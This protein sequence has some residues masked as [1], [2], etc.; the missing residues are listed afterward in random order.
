MIKSALSSSN[1]DGADVT[2]KAGVAKVWTV[3]DKGCSP[4][5]T[6]TP[7]VPPVE[8]EPQ[9]EPPSEA[10]A[11]RRRRRWPLIVAG[12]TVVVLAIIAIVVAT[13]TSQE[14]AAFDPSVG[15]Y[16]GSPAGARAA[17]DPC[18]KTTCF[19][20]PSVVGLSVDDAIATLS[21][22]GFL[23]AQSLRTQPSGTVVA[24]QY[25]AAGSRALATVSMNFTFRAPPAPPAPARAITAREW[26]LIAKSP[27]QH[28]GERIIVYGEVTQFDAATG[29]ST[30]RANVDGIAHRVRYGY[31]DYETNTVLAGS[32]TLLEDLVADD[33]FRAEATV[34][35]SLSYRTT[36]GGT[37]TVPK[38]EVTAITVTGSTK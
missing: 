14:S 10:S 19:T 8:P 33:L 30:F 35:G 6:D 26:A 3:R 4:A 9:P 32:A 12:G 20:V 13:S 1:R 27:D 22:A 29:A 7:P 15:T 16:P 24:S 34:Q 18:A 5:M 36:M 11:G 31:A 38:L 2:C 23:A 25:P 21:Q 37:I 17:T 28:T